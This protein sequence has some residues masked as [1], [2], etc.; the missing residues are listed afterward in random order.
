VPAP[1][2]GLL[3]PVSGEL[4]PLLVPP[5]LAVVIPAEPPLP[6]SE[7]FSEHAGNAINQAKSQP[8]DLRS[9]TPRR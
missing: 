4:P 1:P 2:V 8:E 7:S 5:L 9:V 3:P 6:A